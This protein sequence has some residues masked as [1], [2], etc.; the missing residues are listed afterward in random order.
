MGGLRVQDYN[1]G[2]IVTIDKRVV[3]VILHI[4]EDRSDID[5]CPS[6]Q[7]LVK[8]CRSLQT[9]RGVVVRV[10]LQRCVRLLAIDKG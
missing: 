4:G 1:A 2:W 5:V 8:T 6:F 9:D 3:L 7:P 10:D